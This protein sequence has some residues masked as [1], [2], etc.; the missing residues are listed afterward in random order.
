MTKTNSLIKGGF[1]CAACG[2]KLVEDKAPCPDTGYRVF[3]CPPCDRNEIEETANRF[4]EEY[5]I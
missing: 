2:E 4:G 3:R 1:F 5:D